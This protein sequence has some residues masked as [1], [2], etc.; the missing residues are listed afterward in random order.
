M[1]DTRRLWS[2][3]A[4]A[5]MVLVGACRSFDVA[6]ENAPTTDQLE[7]NPTR[8]ILGRA[9]TGI[10]TGVAGVLNDVGGD[11]Q[12]YGIYGRELYNLAGNDPRETGE[13]LRGPQDP[14]GRAGAGWA[15]KYA[16]IRS[17]NIY[18]RGVTNST[19][20]SEA[21]KRASLGFAK[22]IKAWFFH[23]LIV[24]TGPLGIPMDVDRA[25]S[26]EP[27]PFVSQTDVYA[28]IVALLDEARTDL[29]AGG[30]TFP[31]VF[32]PGWTG[33]T[34]PADFIRFNRG[35][36]ARVQVTRALLNGCGAPCFTGA[37]T[38][39]GESFIT[40][41]S[42]PLSL[43]TGV[44]IAYDVAAGEPANPITENLTALRY[45]VHPSIPALVQNR[46]DGSKDLRWTTKFREG[47]SKVLNDLTGT[48]KPILY[49]TNS[50]TASASN[51]SADIPLLKNEELILLRAEANLGLGN[52]QAAID[53]INLIRVQSGGLEPSALTAASSSTA[54][55]DELLYN[56]LMSLIFEQGVRWIDARK[57]NRLAALPRDR[58]GD[59]VH[60]H[61]IVPTAECDARALA[62][63]CNPLGN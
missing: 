21:E 12:Q 25:I 47:T 63:P 51:L 54:I 45:Y 58:A 56:R 35:L 57:Y 43:T 38:A 46:G 3:A 28:A 48:I 4:L 17:I 5:G 2:R 52:R 8:A 60:E 26:D 29:A 42:L 1:I 40:S 23:R 14:G 36:L 53:D 37:L 59:V 62:V 50:A 9:A 24:R 30:G 6:N 13:E 44:Y 39:L 55:L 11:I 15:N 34:T 7:G 49:N 31:F 16:H 32:A 20:L 19:E 10:F 27:A 61:Q 18:I 22:T 41:A 33:F